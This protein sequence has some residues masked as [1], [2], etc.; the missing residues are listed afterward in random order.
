MSRKDRRAVRAAIVKSAAKR[1]KC[2]IKD[3]FRAAGAAKGLRDVV[4]N[5]NKIPEI[6]IAYARKILGIK[7]REQQPALR[8]RQPFRRTA[9]SLST[10]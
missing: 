5:L 9:I 2:T 6:V 10:H 1:R 8:W 4:V 7:P 3:F